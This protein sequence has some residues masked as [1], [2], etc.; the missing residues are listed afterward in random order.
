MVHE[1]APESDHEVD[2]EAVLSHYELGHIM[3]YAL[4]SDVSEPF[5][6]NSGQPCSRDAVQ[7]VLIELIQR[8]QSFFLMSNETLVLIVRQLES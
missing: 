6:Y 3:K 8:P 1:P 4:N 2:G 5:L 7:A